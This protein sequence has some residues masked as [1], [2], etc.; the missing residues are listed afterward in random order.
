MNFQTLSTAVPVQGVDD[1]STV[2]KGLRVMD[3]FDVF[4]AVNLSTDRAAL[5]RPARLFLILEQKEKL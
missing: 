5:R 2:Q 4:S 3:R 1:S